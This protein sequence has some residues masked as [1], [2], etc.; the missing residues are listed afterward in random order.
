MNDTRPENAVDHLLASLSKSSSPIDDAVHRVLQAVR[1]HLGMDVAFISEFQDGQRV[2]RYID[3]AGREAPIQVGDA[4]PLDEGY[5]QPVVDGRLPE[6]IPDTAAVPAAMALPVTTALPVGAHLSVPIRLRDGRIYGTFCC[7]SFAPDHSLNER[8]LHMMR[9]LAD[10]TGQ[11]I[12]SDLKTVQER[13]EKIARVKTVME[14]D[15]LSILY[16]PI[17]RLDT[18]SV[19]GFECLAR[20]SASPSRTPDVWFSEAAEVGLGVEL[21]VA[22][23]R[24]ALAGL[25]LLSADTLVGVNVSPAAILSGELAAVLKD[26]PAER[27]VLEVT[28]HAPVSDYADLLQALEPLRRRGLRLAVDDAGAGYASLRHI[29]NLRP[30]AIKIDMGLTRGID[31]D[32]ARHALTSALIA[33]ARDMG[34]QIIAEGV[35]TEAELGTLRALGVGHA[36]GYLLGRPMPLADAAQMLTER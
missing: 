36:Q 34:S 19:V 5:C 30:D 13:E 10:L 26:L 1:S 25:S 4:H 14:Q 20:F 15:Q 23:I 3:A 9:A 21:E 31:S 32:P 2:F 12:D 27:I 18:D 22:A 33:F 11:R 16:Q 29:L 7:F 24:K 35:E 6:L 28:E 17:Y 8:D